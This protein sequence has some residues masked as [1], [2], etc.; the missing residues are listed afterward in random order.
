MEIISKIRELVVKPSISLYEC[1]ICG[2]SHND[3][4]IYLWHIRKCSGVV[5]PVPQL[6]TRKQAQVIV[7][8]L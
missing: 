2:E 1:W 3:A 8:K 5:T 6:E 7:A 4:V